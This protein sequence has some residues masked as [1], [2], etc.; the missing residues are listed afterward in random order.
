MNKKSVVRLL[1]VNWLLGC[2]NS[3]LFVCF[4]LQLSFCHSTK[5]HHFY[6]DTKALVK[7]SCPTKYFQ[8]ILYLQSLLF[9]PVSF[10]FALLSYSKIIRTVLQIK[11]RDSRSKVFSTCTSHL[12]VLTLFYG[13]FIGTYMNP[14][15]ENS[16]MFDQI[17]SVLYTAVTPMLNPLIYSLRNKDLKHALFFQFFLISHK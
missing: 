16:E 14:V 17:F 1:C 6:C 3:S 10:M 4:A 9:G 8:I 11:S 2:L 12:I 13:T 7:I 15:L 5:I